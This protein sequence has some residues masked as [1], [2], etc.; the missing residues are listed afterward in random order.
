[1]RDYGSV[2]ILWLDG[3]W[4]R[5]DSTINDE[6]RSWGYDISKWEQDIEMPGI[7][8]MARRYQPGLLIVDRSVHWPYENYRTPEQSI[9]SE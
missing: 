9:P 1:M 7:A 8:R 3:G 5:P 2:D 6:V 4:I